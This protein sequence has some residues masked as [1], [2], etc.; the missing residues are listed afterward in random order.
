MKMTACNECEFT[1]IRRPGTHCPRPQCP[2][3][4]QLP[5]DDDA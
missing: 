1:D 3:I 5:E 4:M 2:G